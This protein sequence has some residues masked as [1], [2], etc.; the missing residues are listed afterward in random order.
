MSETNSIQGILIK[1]RWRQAKRMI[2]ELGSYAV[3]LL[4]ILLAFIIYTFYIH[5]DE[6]ASEL[7]ILLF[8]VSIFII[9]QSRKDKDFL[10]KHVPNYQLEMSLEYLMLVLPFTTASL[11]FFHA[12]PM[13]LLVIWLIIVPYINIVS[14]QKKYNN[15]IK[16]IPASMFEWKSGVRKSFVP[17]VFLYV[18]ALASSWFKI[19]PLIIL[20]FICVIVLSFYDENETLE[21]LHEY[22]ITSKGFLHRKLK[23]HLTF[24]LL[25]FTPILLINIFFNI[26]Y[27]LIIILFMLAYCTIVAFGI[28]SKYKHYIPSISVMKNSN[29]TSVIALICALPGFFIVPLVLSFF[30]YRNAISNLKNYLPQ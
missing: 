17:L 29:F 9:H 18:C 1:I 28:T 8:G 25:F 24:V 16:Y 30:Y 5:R 7:L 21:V 2:F 14:N 4:L 6:K 11:Y 12:W 23:D 10:I 22:A 13:V 20:W 3:F 27:A 19:L 26:E 15:F